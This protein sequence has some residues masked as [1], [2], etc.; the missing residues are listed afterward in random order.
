MSRKSKTIGALCASAVIVAGVG[1]GIAVADRNVSQEIENKQEAGYNQGFQDGVDSVKVSVE[2][3]PEKLEEIKEEI[4]EEFKET[5]KTN[6]ALF[7]AFQSLMNNGD[8]MG[9]SDTVLALKDEE[10]GGCYILDIETKKCAHL[11]KGE[12]ITFVNGDDGDFNYPFISTEKE[13]VVY[14]VDLETYEPEEIAV[15]I[16]KV[17]QIYK[18]A[19]LNQML[20]I[21][22]G[23]ICRLN[24]DN[25]TT[26]VYTDA[27][28]NISYNWGSYGFS[29]NNSKNS[30][31]ITS[32]SNGQTQTSK[33]FEW[34]ESIGNFKFVCEVPGTIRES[35]SYDDCKIFKVEG[36]D[37]YGIY[38]YSIADDNV[39]K[40]SNEYNKVGGRIGNNIL[41]GSKCNMYTGEDGYAK[42]RYNLAF[43]NISTKTLNENG[44]EMTHTM[45]EQIGGLYLNDTLVS[46]ENE[47]IYISTMTMFDG[48]PNTMTLHRITAN[49]DGSLKCDEEFS[50]KAIQEIYKTQTTSEYVSFTIRLMDTG[51]TENWKYN[52][53]S[54]Q[55]EQLGV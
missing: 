54:R 17:N 30:F 16:K 45:H 46:S 23:G 24:S 7:G 31:S 29:V 5:E 10:N 42:S 11:F 32:P 44:P 3:P 22:K 1:T 26:A 55:F 12:E 52:I 13:N 20:L 4:R 9:Y 2:I 50:T 15:P 39:E 25:S 28:V 53:T 18:F 27:E 38:V 37:V 14:K 33:F 21:G 36:N 6:D 49:E 47:V 43:Y 40:I 48:Q 19:E 34:D 35:I 51:E 8:S 41:L